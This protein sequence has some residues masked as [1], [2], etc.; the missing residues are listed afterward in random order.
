MKAI[1]VDVRFS[2][3]RRSL[4]ALSRR[5]MLVVS[6]VLVS[7]TAYLTGLLLLV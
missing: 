6:G 3:A 1:L 4:L 2:G 7:L 5:E